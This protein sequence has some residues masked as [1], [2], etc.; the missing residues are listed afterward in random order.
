[1]DHVGVVVED[2]PAAVAFVVELGLELEGEA[3]VEG[4]WADHLLGLDD[5]LVD[6]ATMRIETTSPAVGPRQR[7]AALPCRIERWPVSS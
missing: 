1:M 5:V 2:L 3:S 4:D 6:I 7:A